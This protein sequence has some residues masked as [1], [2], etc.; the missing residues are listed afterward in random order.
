MLMQ[1]AVYVK[2]WQKV[3]LKTVG[4]EPTRVS[5]LRDILIV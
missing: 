2:K 1:L 4:F 3:M 5:P